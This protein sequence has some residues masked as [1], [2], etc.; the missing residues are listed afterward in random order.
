MDAMAKREREY[1]HERDYDTLCRAEEVRS[2]RKR[3]NGAKAHH[4]K[5][6]KR[7]SAV[8]RSLMKGGR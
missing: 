1:E 8:G 3:M 5:V 7:H 4:R 2:D 6:S